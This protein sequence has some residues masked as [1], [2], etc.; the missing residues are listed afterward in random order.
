MD[1]PKF[2]IGEIVIY[3]NPNIDCFRQ[4]IVMEAQFETKITKPRWKYVLNDNHLFSIEED[5]LIKIV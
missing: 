5:D 1:N 2:K 3:K 4:Y